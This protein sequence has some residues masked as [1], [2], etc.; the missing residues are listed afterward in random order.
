MY[1]F[2]YNINEELHSH[3]NNLHFRQPD[4]LPTVELRD[5]MLAAA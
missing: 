4:C 3:Y 1:I 2:S 5:Q